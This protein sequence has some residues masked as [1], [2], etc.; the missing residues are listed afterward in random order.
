MQCILNSGEVTQGQ[1]VQVMTPGEPDPPEIMLKSVE[2]MK[3]EIGWQEPKTY[4]GEK[5]RAYEVRIHLYVC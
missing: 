1:P 2:S 4:G 3:F 5:I